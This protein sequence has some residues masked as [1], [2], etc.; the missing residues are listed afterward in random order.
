M[1]G[2]T[3]ARRQFTDGAG[4]TQYQHVVRRDV[5][6][7]TADVPMV[8]ETGGA[9]SFGTSSTGN[10]FDA[11]TSAGFSAALTVAGFESVVLKSEFSKATTTV[12]IRLWY[13]DADGTA[14]PGPVVTLVHSGVVHHATN[15][16]CLKSGY[17]HGELVALPTYGAATIKFELVSVTNSAAVSAW[18]VAR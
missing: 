16:P 6:G 18:G 10:V 17:Y 5:G 12:K 4:A 3:T 11:R 15:S 8:R 9:L 14:L 2:S 7:N 13:I 1:A